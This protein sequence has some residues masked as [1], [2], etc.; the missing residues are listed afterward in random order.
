[1][2]AAVPLRGNA[3]GA[4][5]M[6]LPRGDSKLQPRGRSLLPVSQIRTFYRDVL[7]CA[8]TALNPFG[9]APC[10]SWLPSAIWVSLPTLTADRDFREAS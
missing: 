4:T 9:A 8:L 3:S 5:V 7:P 2:Y 6:L 10:H 1:M